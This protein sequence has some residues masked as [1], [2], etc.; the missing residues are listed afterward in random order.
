MDI[1][2]DTSK[3]NIYLH[4]LAHDLFGV[5]DLLEDAPELELQGISLLLQQPVASAGTL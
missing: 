4:D 1:K 2:T 3:S 5:D